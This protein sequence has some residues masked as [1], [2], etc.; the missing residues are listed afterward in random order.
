MK[1][2]KKYLYFPLL[3]IAVYGI[4]ISCQDAPSFF[5][6]NSTKHMFN[7]SEKSKKLMKI[8][9]KNAHQVSQEH[10][11]NRPKMIETFRITMDSSN[12]EKMPVK[13]LWL[14][15]NSTTMEDDIDQVQDGI[16]GFINALKEDHGIDITVTF[17]S[18]IN[19]TRDPESMSYC[20]PQ[21]VSDH[22]SITIYDQV[23]Q[24]T[25]DF[26]VAALLLGKDELFNNVGINKSS[27]LLFQTASDSD[28][29]RLFFLQF[30]PSGPGQR[31]YPFEKNTSVDISSLS[32]YFQNHGVNVIISVTDDRSA[33]SSKA[34]LNFLELNYGSRSSFKFF[35]YINQEKDTKYGNHYQ[36][37]AKELGGQIFDIS[38]R[39]GK[40]TAY[41]IFFKDLAEQIKETTIVNTFTLKSKCLAVKKVILDKKTLH[42]S[43]YS[44]KDTDLIINKNAITGNH[45]LSVKYY[46]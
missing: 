32:S 44:C 16:N 21:S 18:C 29:T 28:T 27:N 17:V 4:L 45:D 36:S 9:T 14:I 8:E 6:Q 11:D 43:L 1:S 13:M 10:L 42:P 31:P 7:Q 30:T 12:Q 34:F 26:G 24:S 46:Q 25:D 15:D 19:E 38:S 35:G 23:I 33:M 22:P 2:L 41:G 39:S 3:S 5:D 20:I 40:Q 37:L